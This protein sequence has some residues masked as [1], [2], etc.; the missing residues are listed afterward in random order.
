MT[1]RYELEAAY[2]KGLREM[3]GMDP[4]VAQDL[5]F[6][7]S[8]EEF[9]ATLQSHTQISPRTAAREVSHQT[10]VEL[11][12]LQTDEGRNMRYSLEELAEIDSAQI[13]ARKSIGNIALRD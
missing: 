11:H 13:A 8:P 2:Y 9:E 12:H 7:T 5:G 1:Q 4:E 3:N 10:N 6:V